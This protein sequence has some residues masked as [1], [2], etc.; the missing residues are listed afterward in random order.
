MEN[1]KNTIIDSVI[2]ADTISIIQGLKI[3]PI[4]E[5][6]TLI[7]AD[8]TLIHMNEFNEYY[9]QEQISDLEKKIEELKTNSNITSFK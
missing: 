9:T 6:M 5:I 4:M 1:T 7:I 3:E 8:N 2:R